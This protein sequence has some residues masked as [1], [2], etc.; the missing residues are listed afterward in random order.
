MIILFSC[1]IISIVGFSQCYVSK[2]SLVRQLRL[3]GEEKHIFVKGNDLKSVT[4]LNKSGN[5]ETITIA[6]RTG[7][8]IFQKNNSKKT[9]YFNTISITDSTITGSKTHFFNAFIKP[10]PLDSVTKIEILK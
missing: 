6:D 2:D 1:L 7:I 10:I 9:L 5:L 4:C 8:K 3:T